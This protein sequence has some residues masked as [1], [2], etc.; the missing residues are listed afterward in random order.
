MLISKEILFKD[1]KTKGYKAEILEK[2]YRLLD[3][4]KQLLSIPYLQDRL[5]LKGGTALNLFYFERLPRLSVDID[6]NY[7]G[8]LD[9]EKMLEDKQVLIDTIH[10]VL[11]QNQFELH[12]SP[13]Q[14]AGGKMVW[15]YNSVLGQRG[16]LEI[17]INFMYRQLLY[18]LVYQSPKLEGYDDWKAPTLDIHELAAGKLSALFNRCTS[19]DLFDSHYLMTKTTLN[20]Q[21]LREGLIPYFAITKVDTTA[22]TP[23]SIEY[24]LRDLKNRLL[25]VMHQQDFPRSLPLLKSWATTMIA[26]LREGLSKILPLNDNEIEFLHK[27]RTEG[28][29]QTELI[30]TNTVLSDKIQS[31]PAL[32]WVIQ[33]I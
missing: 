11:L 23:Q 16:T 7:V 20:F 14:H 4:F 8:H 18:P 29:I 13:S 10:N 15:F 26:E 5:V 33:Q 17:D 12:R 1:A 22:L 30:T 24:N 32:L 6:L 9:R 3:T 25:P 31:H 19:R 28:I 21:K 27:I 2:V